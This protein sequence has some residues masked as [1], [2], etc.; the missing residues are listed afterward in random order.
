MLSTSLTN[1]G[2]VKKSQCR[3]LWLGCSSAAATKPAKLQQYGTD[4]AQKK[5]IGPT[6]TQQFIQSSKQA[7]AR[8]R[9]RV[10][11]VR[12]ALDY[13]DFW[14]LFTRR[15]SRRDRSRTRLRRCRCC[16]SA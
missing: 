13:L 5:E 1:Y 4:Q 8:A 3:G 2:L 10:S 16:T 11:A 9:C 12:V 14:S 15:G 6:F 7:M